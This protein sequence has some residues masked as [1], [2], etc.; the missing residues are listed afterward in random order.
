MF[1]E[2][3]VLITNNFLKNF[4]K[5]GFPIFENSRY[6][7]NV[8]TKGWILEDFLS[9]FFFENFYVCQYF[10][11][12]VESKKYVFSIKN[13]IFVQIFKGKVENK[14][15]RFFP[16]IFMFVNIFFRGGWKQKIHF[17]FKIFVFINIFKE[18]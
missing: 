18:G 16:K 11:R 17:S 9:N 6:Q 12:E 8:W 14:K 2:R 3:Y 7:T 15:V 5:K 4:Q 1:C 10:L 13:F